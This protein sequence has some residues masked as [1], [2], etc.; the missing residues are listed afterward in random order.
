MRF[1][2]D[3]EINLDKDDLLETSSYVET[4]INIVKRCD[5]PFTIGLLG[6]WGSGK[7]SIVR[8]LQEK[9]NN[10]SDSKIKVFIYDAW[11]Y[12]KDDLRRTFLLKLREFANLDIKEEK[13][14]FYQDKTEEIEYKP[15]LDKWFLSVFGI[16]F[17]CLI[18]PLTFAFLWGFLDVEDFIKGIGGISILS[19][20]I[21]FIM[22]FLKSV[23]IYHK[24]TITTPKMFAPEN[25]EERFKN[26]IKEYFD[27]NKQLEKL[28]IVIDNI[29]RCHKELVV[30]TLL[31]VKNF[32]ELP[33]VV[34]IIP[35]DE[36]AL[37]K[38]LNLSNKDANE[39]LRK[40]FNTIIRIRKFTNID[41]FNICK[42]LNEKYDLKFSDEVLSIV[43]QEFAN[44]PRR[45][46]QFLNN[47][48]SE[49][50][51]SKKLKI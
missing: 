11:K 38:Y 18:A 2:P 26:T 39:F 3:K 15:K 31:T 19:G 23:F 4:L 47:L 7:S 43:A 16:I 29:D 50:L 44:N 21:T 5:T 8:T 20:I 30:E 28:I 42:E 12:S 34:F 49:V 51:L 6:G 25:F 27:K 13:E 9:F 33:K 48:Q 22:Q 24:V 17:I 45:V 46:I 41:L 1:I 10:D 37:K 32:L 14:L 40:L 36:D 35:V